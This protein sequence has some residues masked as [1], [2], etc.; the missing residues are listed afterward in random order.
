MTQ[1]NI[2]KIQSGYDKKL[3]KIRLNDLCS[4]HRALRQIVGTSRGAI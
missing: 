4:W 3:R 1:K 2:L